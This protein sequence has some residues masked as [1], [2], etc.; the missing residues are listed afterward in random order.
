[1]VEKLQFDLQNLWA[2]KDDFVQKFFLVFEEFQ[3]KMTSGVCFGMRMHDIE[4]IHIIEF[5]CFT[6]QTSLDSCGHLI[7]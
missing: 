5:L 2:I 3:A 4:I 1:M 6:F 7:I